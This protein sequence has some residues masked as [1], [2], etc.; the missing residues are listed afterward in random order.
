MENIVELPG[1]LHGA[2]SGSLPQSSAEGCKKKNKTAPR[3]GS[4][5]RG[6]KSGVGLFCFLDH[7]ARDS[8]GRAGR[9]RRCDCV[10]HDGSA[11][12]AEDRVRLIA[13]SHVWSYHA[14]VSRAVG[15]DDQHK[16]GDVARGRR[17][18]IVGCGTCWAE[19][20]SG[21]LEIRSLAFGCLVDVDRVIA[22]GQAL[23]VQFDFH[24]VAS[25]G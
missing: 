18:V 11:A 1:M 3:W 14:Y 6:L 17:A 15:S 13:H 16:V 4:G 23:D 5:R 20:R 8:G 24:A 19:M 2:D 10:N 21:G 22:W 12:V 7:G 9:T 25:I